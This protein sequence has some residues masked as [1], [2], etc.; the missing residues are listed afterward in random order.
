MLWHLMPREILW[1]A[2][3]FLGSLPGNAQRTKGKSHLPFGFAV[4]IYV[5][6]DK[7]A[8]SVAPFSVGPIFV[9]IS[10][11]A[12]D[13]SG[14]KL[15]DKRETRWRPTGFIRRDGRL[16]HGGTRHIDEISL[17]SPSLGAYPGSRTQ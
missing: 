1:S 15:P 12:A 14:R 5:G 17:V 2:H 4:Q 10:F 6:T 11:Q 3:S 16:P 9:S 8:G 7:V 13:D